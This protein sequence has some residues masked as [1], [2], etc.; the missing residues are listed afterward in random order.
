MYTTRRSG[1]DLEDARLHYEQLQR[2][3]HNTQEQNEAFRK[4][5][6]DTNARWKAAL[7]Q[8]KKN[9]RGEL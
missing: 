5:F 9:V 7:K 8:D 1:F 4:A 2:G 3:K 6:D